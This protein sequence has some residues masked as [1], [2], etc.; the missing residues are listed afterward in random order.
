MI[1]FLA[2]MMLGCL[3]A[4]RQAPEL[5]GLVDV[6]GSD[7]PLAKKQDA[8]HEL[9][10]AGTAA[11][12]VLIRALSDRRLY[13]RRD[14]ANRMNLPVTAKPPEPLVAEISVGERCKEL[15][16]DIITP[17][18]HSP[19]AGNFKVFSE[20]ML[21]VDDWEA[22]WAANER[23]SLAEIHRDLAPLVDEYWKQHGT[24]QTVEPIQWEQGL[25]V[26]GGARK[27][28]ALGGATSLGPGRNVVLTVYE[29]DSSVDA[30]TR[31]YERHLYDS[32]R[33]SSGQEGKE[34]VMFETARGDIKLAQTI[35][36]TRITIARRDK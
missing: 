26:P 13:Q 27:N 11:I 25:P 36:G 9:V 19:F 22:W 16:Y 1:T 31:F 7:V 18:H 35:S 8:S 23:K 20:Q 21:R 3:M 34:E 10:A 32:K 14:I 28:D 29:V 15:L 12:P 2:T 24:T 30:I 4:C 33:S 17:R 6:L 5:D